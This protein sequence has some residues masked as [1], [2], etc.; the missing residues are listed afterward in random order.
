MF[1]EAPTDVEIRTDGVAVNDEGT[2]YFS[3]VSKTGGVILSVESDGKLRLVSGD[4]ATSASEPPENG[5]E[6]TNATY[7]GEYGPRDLLFAPNGALIFEDNGV[8]LTLR[9]DGTVWKLLGS[10]DD[11]DE[12][13]QPGDPATI[14]E[15]GGTQNSLA[16]AADGTV[17][18]DDWGDFTYSDTL[19]RVR[20]GLATDSLI[21]GSSGRIA[22]RIG[23][24]HE[25]TLDAMTGATRR[26]IEY[27]GEGRA[28]AFVDAYGNRTTV[29]RDGDGR[30]AAIEAPTGQRTTF[31]HDSNGYLSTATLPDGRVIDFAYTRDGLLTRVADAAG[32]EWTFAYDSQGRVEERTTPDG[33]TL[34]ARQETPGKATVTQISPE[35][36]ETSHTAEYVDGNP[37]FTTSCC[38]GVESSTVIKSQ[39]WE[40]TRPDGGSRTLR[41]GPD[42]RFGMLAPVTERAVE[43]SPGGR[44]TTTETERT[45]TLSDR[46][47]PLSV[48]SHTDTITINGS[49]TYERVFD[50]AENEFTITTPEGRSSVLTLDDNAAL[51]SISVD[52]VDPVTIE[53]NG[54]GRITKRKQAGTVL[55][56]E[57]DDNGYLAA[58]EDETGRR[59]E[60]GRDVVGRIE[61]ATEAGATDGAATDSFTY[62]DAGNITAVERPNGDG[63]EFVQGEAGRLT[64][65]EPPEAPDGGG[66]AFSYDADGLVTTLDPPSGRT[67]A[68]S[69]DTYGRLTGEEPVADGSTLPATSFDRD[70]AGRIRKLTWSPGTGSDQ[71]VSIE[72]DGAA[73]TAIEYGGAVSGR[74]EYDHDAN[75]FVTGITFPDDFGGSQTHTISHDDDG[76]TTGYG[77][78]TLT[79]DGPDGAPT[80][81]TDGT[82]TIRYTYDN[83]GR[84]D[85]RTHEVNGTAFYEVDYT[86]DEAGRIESRTRTVDG[87][88]VPPETF[89]Y[90]DAGRL[91]GRTGGTT[92]NEAYGYDANGNRTARTLATTTLTAAIRSG[93]RL[94]SHDQVTGQGGTTSV[95]YTY[96]ADGF[97]SGRGGDRF[98]YSPK[99][100]LLE[101]TPDGGST[102]TYTNDAHGRIVARTVDGDT[103]EY[104][105]GDPNRPW[106]LTVARAP[107]GT[108]TRYYYD[109]FGRVVALDR[110]GTWHYVATDQVG[111]PR[112]VAAA[113]GSIEK[114]LKRDSYGVV[115]NDSNPGFT[116][117]VDF[118]GGIRDPDT[119]LVRLG[120][121]DYEPRTGRF[122]ARDPI[123]L[124]SGQFNYYTYA[125]G[126]PVNAVD[127]TGLASC[128]WQE[129]VEDYNT[130]MDNASPVRDL[131]GEISG[132]RTG[133]QGTV[134]DTLKTGAEEAVKAGAKEGVEQLAKGA[135]RRAAATA[136]G[137]A[138]AG[139]GATAVGTAAATE[140]ALR[141]SVFTTSGISNMWD[142]S[143]TDRIASGLFEA[144]PLGLQTVDDPDNPLDGSDD[145]PG[146]GGSDCGSKSPDN[147]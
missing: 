22:H 141:A 53:R 78:F 35:G 36:R 99:G 111:S 62:D 115:L 129:T 51:D 14:R 88:S 66:I 16:V 126:D 85:T 107:D 113:D 39:N 28:E 146:G 44:E 89:T 137:G 71:T 33:T 80:E 4:G 124:A 79:R 136:A 84:V 6:A 41:Q 59:T 91:D 92:P 46:T 119:G 130:T 30:L 104:L 145:G 77:P 101:A 134:E 139:A 67:I 69:Y 47:D 45:V 48:Q 132:D 2:V 19:G 68:S 21:A 32:T 81:L 120:V 56:L 87:A 70:G 140:V 96:D 72:R 128:W 40:I 58:V 108:R 57:Y 50:G 42:P 90:D 55:K 54:D 135:S 3:E 25:K 11:S 20:T 60:F 121:R 37:K 127:R 17:V 112:V 105:Y 123:L 43:T 29:E 73:V 63:H 109:P 95:S 27:D 116:L 103:T 13:L 122:T 10:G 114:R 100:D 117:H 64:R 1:D 31:D 38:G 98:T 147:C 76:L 131:I 5:T 8:L 102:V 49:R 97:V 106:Q 15:W 110:G 61:S 24:R 144:D 143:L 26:T 142:R 94:R 34:F 133:P 93:D 75:G 52:G 82:L 9:N 65:Y 138:A 18:F 23:D 125:D 83:R 74:F 7:S 118:A 12:D 86:Y